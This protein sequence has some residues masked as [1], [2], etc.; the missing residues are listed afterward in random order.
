MNVPGE[1]TIPLSHMTA[2]LDLMLI[3]LKTQ[4]FAFQEFSLLLISNI[5]ML[6]PAK[7][8]IWINGQIFLESDG[9][10]HL[11][12]QPQPPIARSGAYPLF[13]PASI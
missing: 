3:P 6:A 12:E 1:L 2:G 13:I 8:P 4:D 9:H 10:D 11:L 7:W 5:P